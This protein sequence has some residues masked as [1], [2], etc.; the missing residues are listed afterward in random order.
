M[1]FGKLTTLRL[2][3]GLIRRLAPPPLFRVVLDQ[4][5][6]LVESWGGGGCI[7]CIFRSGEGSVPV[8]ELMKSYLEIAG[9]CC[10]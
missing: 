10:R 3:L 4:A 5:D 1:F 2:R 8:N 7:S 9:K 6:E